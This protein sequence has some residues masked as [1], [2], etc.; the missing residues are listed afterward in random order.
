V[1]AG[2][3][4]KNRA[5][6]RSKKFISKESVMNVLEKVKNY[7]ELSFIK[8][9]KIVHTLSQQVPL[10]HIRQFLDS[11]KSPI[12]IEKF[13]EEDYKKVC[14]MLEVDCTLSSMQIMNLKKPSITT[15]PA[16]IKI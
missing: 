4:I 7:N 16:G 1:I 13:F 3:F 14:E 9:T 5:Q 2:I 11:P 15:T 8:I 10:E 12:K 6:E